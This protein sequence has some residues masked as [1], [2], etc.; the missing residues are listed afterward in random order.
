MSTKNTKGS[1]QVNLVKG[2]EVDD[3]NLMKYDEF[4]ERVDFIPCRMA[5]T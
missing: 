3:G 1:D 4:A 5:L 2:V